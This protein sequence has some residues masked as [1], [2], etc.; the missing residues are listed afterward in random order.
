VSEQP[1]ST[2]GKLRTGEH[3]RLPWCSGVHVRVAA[4]DHNA[5]QY[6]ADGT[7]IPYHFAPWREVI[8][9]HYTR[10]EDANV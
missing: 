6:L 2:F 3:F 1:T 4:I 10:M 8:Q 5:E 7:V 9:D